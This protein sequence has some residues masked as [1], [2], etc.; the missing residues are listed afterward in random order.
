M[1]MIAAVFKIII[2]RGRGLK[3]RCGRGRHPTLH[4]H[5]YITVFP[6]LQQSTLCSDETA[7]VLSSVYCLITSDHY[8]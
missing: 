8:I 7:A 3:V 1:Q 4:L 6:D 2:L 5:N